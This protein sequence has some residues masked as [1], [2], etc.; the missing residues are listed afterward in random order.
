MSNSSLLSRIFDTMKTFWFGKNQNNFFTNLFEFG[1]NWPLIL[2][3]DSNISLI[4]VFSI[5]QLNESS[6]QLN[7]TVK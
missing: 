2:N 6:V 1:K 3:Q 7:E 4:L 5:F